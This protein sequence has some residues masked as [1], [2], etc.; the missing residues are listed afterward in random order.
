MASFTVYTKASGDI[1]RRGR[2]THRSLDAAQRR[3]CSTIR[4][5]I[6]AIVVN[7]S[8]GEEHAP[9]CSTKRRARRKSKP[10]SGCGCGG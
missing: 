7:N 9:S 6:N 1:W 2:K 3:A 10:L 8:T 4:G 5:G